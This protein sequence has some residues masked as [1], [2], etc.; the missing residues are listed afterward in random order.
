MKL[1]NKYLAIIYFGIL[2]HK[3]VRQI[4]KELY[5]S[6]VNSKVVDKKL[7]TFAGK[8]ATKLKK[9]DKGAGKY[10]GI[11]LAGLANILIS[12]LIDKGLDEKMKK[13][14]NS[15]TRDEAERKKGQIIEE[16]IKENRKQGKVFYLAS[17]HNDCAIDHK[18]YQGKIYVDKDW[19]QYDYDGLIGK[20]IN[21]HNIKTVQWVM[22]EPAW[23][24]TR[25]NCR[26]YFISLKTDDILNKSV[27]KLKEDNNSHSKEGDRE[28]QT[29]RKMNLEKY[30]EK[31]RTLEALYAKYPTEKLKRMIDKVKML[32]QRYS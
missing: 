31:L 3:T 26:H 25:P 8:T 22:G 21:N 15:S 27:K 4:H 10:I 20:Y 1:K 13:I 29:P 11:G 5:D 30:K 12:E 16:N 23:F 9:L 14:I 18:P 28:Y 24:I 2:R 17:S 32:I 7:L 6:T 19:K